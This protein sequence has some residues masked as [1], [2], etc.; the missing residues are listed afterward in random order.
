MAKYGSIPDNLNFSHPNNI[1][2]MTKITGRQTLYTYTAG[3]EG[4]LYKRIANMS[5][6]L[7][8]GGVL[9]FDSTGRWLMYG[10]RNLQDALA[11]RVV[12]VVAAVKP[13]TI[14]S[15]S[16]YFDFKPI[17]AWDS[18][19][20][21][22]QGETPID[23]R[24]RKGGDFEA[25]HSDEV[26]F[27][28]TKTVYAIGI[29]C[30]ADEAYGHSHP[31]SRPPQDARYGGANALGTIAYMSTDVPMNVPFTRYMK[32]IA[33][34]MLEQVPDELKAYYAGTFEPTLQLCNFGKEMPT[35]AVATYW[36]DGLLTDGY[37]ITSKIFESDGSGEFMAD[38]YTREP[39][40]F[41]FEQ[42]AGNG[43]SYNKET[44]VKKRKVRMV[45]RT[46]EKRAASQ[47]LM[48]HFDFYSVTVPKNPATGVVQGLKIGE[49]RDHHVYERSLVRGTRYATAP[50]AFENLAQFVCEYVDSN[51]AVDGRSPG[52]PKPE[53]AT[54]V[55][56]AANR[57]LE[58]G[59]AMF[60]VF[61]RGTLIEYLT[62]FLND[63][64]AAAKKAAVGE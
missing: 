28:G 54:Q 40:N 29:V 37:T 43:S 16:T 21:R 2:G 27:D 22:E 51:L 53:E 10:R 7:Q 23:A 9:F 59:Q 39:Y 13:T 57:I 33:P 55:E 50:A 31:V 41:Y 48:D 30:G 4:L 8:C 47:P 20:T 44:V 52:S 3:P 49:L 19:I 24:G 25:M 17:A 5:E 14:N 34:K 11:R 26:Y 1:A 63:W 36:R 42:S 15:R 35:I 61:S 58:E 60:N 46:G 38:G 12:G 18:L 32:D 64:D 56:Q 6:A 62:N 45:V